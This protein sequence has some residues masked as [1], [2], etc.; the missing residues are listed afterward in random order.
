M[1]REAERRFLARACA[2]RQKLVVLDIPLLLETEGQRRCDRVAVVSAPAFLQEQRALARPGMTPARLCAIR[3]QQMADR[4]KRRRA[5][6][7]IRSGLDR[8]HAVRQIGAILQG[9]QDMP[10]QAWPWRWRGVGT[11]DG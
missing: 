7:I 4:D 6:F 5:D 9:L 2:Q 8:G 3:R 11:S 1:V 10:G